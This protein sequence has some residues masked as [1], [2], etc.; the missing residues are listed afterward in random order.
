[1]KAKST[2]SITFRITS[3]ARSILETLSEK[4]GLKMNAVVEM[5]IRAFGENPTVK[6]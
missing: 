6:H 2:R 1:M 5:A 3:E 4:N